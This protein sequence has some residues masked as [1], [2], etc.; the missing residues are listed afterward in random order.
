MASAWLDKKV[1][2]VMS[3]SC[4]DPSLQLKVGRRLSDGTKVDVPCPSSI[5]EYNTYMRGVDRGDQIRGYY[6]TRTKCRKFYKYIFWF[7]FDTVITNSYVLHKHYRADLTISKNMTMKQFRLQLADSLIGDYCSRKKLGRTALP[8]AVR[9]VQLIHVPVTK[10]ENSKK[11]RSKCTLCI[12]R[13]VRKDTQWQCKGCSVWL[14]FTGTTN[15]CFNKWH[16]HH[17][18]EE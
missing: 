11:K 7:L 5:S 13:H 12:R 6:K 3:T 4:H 17:C 1:V 15:D 9:P 18:N 16:T 14:C 10:T 8:N 2:M